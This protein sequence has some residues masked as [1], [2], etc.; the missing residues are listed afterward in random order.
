MT[1]LGNETFFFLPL[2]H[3]RIQKLGL[4]EVKQHAHKH[5]A[6]T[7]LSQGT[8]SHLPNFRATFI[9]MATRKVM[10]Q[11]RCMIP[12][13]ELK[14]SDTYVFTM[15]GDPA[16]PNTRLSSQWGIREHVEWVMAL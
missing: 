7:Q 4:R 9:A 12:S 3:L 15:E 10:D 14:S 11:R 13:E 8:N 5:T 16:V 6:S 2:F 1:I